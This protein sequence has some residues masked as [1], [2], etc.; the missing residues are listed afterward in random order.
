MKQDRVGRWVP[1]RPIEHLIYWPIIITL[2]IGLWFG[3]R[4]LVA[5]SHPQLE[6]FSRWIA[7]TFG[8]ALATFMVMGGIFGIAGLV[9]WLGSPKRSTDDS[10]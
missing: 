9:Y 8:E 3:G 7:E 10:R 5:L 2:L 6:A 4:W 1:D